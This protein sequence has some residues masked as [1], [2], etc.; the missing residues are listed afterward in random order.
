MKSIHEKVE[1]LRKNKYFKIFVVILILM[2]L[3]LFY[4]LATEKPPQIEKDME[5]FIRLTK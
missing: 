3:I 4:N 1:R 2:N 5:E